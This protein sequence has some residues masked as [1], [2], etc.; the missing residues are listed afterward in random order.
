[1]P[2]QVSSGKVLEEQHLHLHTRQL[3]YL[4]VHCITLFAVMCSGN[5]D[6]VHR[7]LVD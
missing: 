4:E 3:F 2:G 7:T 6:Y 5:K 1:M